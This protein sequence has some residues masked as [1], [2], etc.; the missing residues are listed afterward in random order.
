MKIWTNISM[1]LK[2]VVLGSLGVVAMGGF[3]LL[4]NRIATEKVQFQ[5]TT[6][7]VDSVKEN[8]K[9]SLEEKVEIAY[10]LVKYQYDNRG[11]QSVEDVKKAAME[12]VKALRFGPGGGRL[13]LDSHI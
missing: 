6:G 10:A 3:A 8:I 1:K 5:A 11:E 12:A 7:I 13:F 2:M 9:A 4:A